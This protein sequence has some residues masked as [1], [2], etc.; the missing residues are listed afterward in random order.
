MKGIFK[1]LTVALGVVTMTSCS[2]DDFFGASNNEAKK[3]LVPGVEDLI[4]DD[5][6]DVTRG[7]RTATGAW[8]YQEGDGLRVYDDK[9]QLYDLYNYEKASS[10]FERDEATSQDLESDPAFVLFPNKM[11]KRGYW[12]KDEGVKAQF[13][14]PQVITYNADSEFDLSGDGSSIGYVCNLP[15]WAPAVL[16]AD[17]TISDATEL[18][19]LTGVLAVFIKE[20]FKNCTYLK[21]T[22]TNQSTKLWGTFDAVLDKENPDNTVLQMRNEN[23]EDDDLIGGYDLYVDLRKVPSSTSVLYIPVIAGANDIKV[24]ASNNTGNDPTAFTDNDWNSTEPVAD[25]TTTYTFRRNGFKRLSKT[26]ELAASNPVEVSQ[27]LEQYKDSKAGTIT[28]NLVKDF[29]INSG[30]ATVGEDIIIPETD[31]NIVINFAKADM[32]VTQTTANLNF[33]VADGA[34]FDNSIKFNASDRITGNI[35]VSVDL[36]DATVV[37]AGDYTKGTSTIAV[38]DAANFAIGDGTTE[39]KAEGV[40]LTKV[41]G[42]F[43]IEEN[44][45]VDATDNNFVLPT[46]LLEA[47]IKGE[48]DATGHELWNSANGALANLTINGGIVTASKIDLSKMETALSIQNATVTAD[49]ATK[50]TIDVDTEADENAST[51]TSATNG[52]NI[53]ANKQLT[54]KGKGTI[55]GDIQTKGDVLIA[56]TAGN[57]EAINGKLTMIGREKSIN[58]VQ[59][60]V[61]S[62][63]VDP[64]DNGT[65]EEPFVNIILNGNDKYENGTATYT[66]GVAAFKELDLITTSGAYINFTKSVWDGSNLINDAYKAT[67]YKKDGT[68]R[69]DAGIYTASQLSYYQTP[70]AL[71]LRF[72][73]NNLDMNN[74]N[75]KGIVGSTS[76]AIVFRGNNKTIEN[77]KLTDTKSGLFS[78]NKA[79]TAM[80]VFNLT[81]KNV[82]TAITAA[83]NSIGALVGESAGTVEATNVK[84]ILGAAFGNDKA[85]YN[86]GGLIGKTAGATLA[87]CSVDATA[88]A[89]SG[90]YNLGG[91][92][93]STSAALTTTGCSFKGSFAQ[94]YVSAETMDVKYAQVGGVVGNVTSNTAD[95]TITDG[96]GTIADLTVA[97][98]AGVADKIYVSGDTDQAGK[99][100]NFYSNNKYIGYCG[101][102]QAAKTIGNVKINNNTTNTHFV[103]ASLFET[104]ANKD[105]GIVAGTTSALY[106]FLWKGVAN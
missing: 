47:T 64:K 16:N 89:I 51:I 69:T 100:F 75:W 33:K 99:F 20:A 70:S 22:A 7:V 80:Q 79:T 84:V 15:M 76:A 104:K 58:L 29:T 66:E 44:A 12:V 49:I 4:D 102:N 2:N 95:V 34:T 31:N 54:I 5:F 93:G 82:Y 74:K 25:Y 77:L 96:S 3:G 68:Q 6:G 36:P 91:L 27:I 94:N 92:V 41:T 35:N 57:I 97:R 48:L 21:L 42:A 61:K 19:H 50:S 98:A 28:L 53:N 23:T 62:I 39:T 56:Q 90:Y 86:I 71:G 32:T 103:P 67:T 73:M 81:L 17:K 65:W 37:L 11:V 106:Y 8:S 38:T 85:S 10:S 72:L 101:K 78:E 52:I 105:A 55:T 63:K 46:E 1:L 88:S 14:I 40:T 60:L 87:G 43:A 18:K 24:F 13:F 45:K 9:L 26:F 30:E 83:K 59:G